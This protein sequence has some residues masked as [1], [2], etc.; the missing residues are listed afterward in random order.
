MNTII[1]G[2]GLAGL[3]LAHSL[4]ENTVILEKEEQLGGLC[5]S[6][7]FKDIM[8]DIG[9]HIIFSKDEETLNFLTS[10]VEC[11]K[12]RRSNKIFFKGRFIKYPFENELSALSKQDRDY[13]LNTFL[14]NPNK[15]MKAK[16]MLDFFTNTFGKGITDLYLKPYNKKI[17]KYDPEHM[18]TQMVERIPI[19]PD[20]D[21][22]KSAEGIATEGYIHQLDF[23]YPKKNGIQD[24]ISS[25]AK[26]IN[27]KAE[28]YNNI[29][30]NRII[31]KDNWIIETNHGNFKSDRIIN[32]MPLHE[33]FKYLERTPNEIKKT[34]SKLEYNSIYIVILNIL[35][36]NLE[37]NFA[38]MV[39]DQ[40]IIFHRVSKLNFLDDSHKTS[41]LMAEVTFREGDHYSKMSKEEIIK[42]VVDDLEKLNFINKKNVISTDLQKIKYAYVIYTLDHK[43]NISKIMNYLNRIG[44]LCCGR[45][46]EFKYLNMD[47]VIK[48]SKDLAEKVNKS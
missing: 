44:I 38:V 5:R 30:I 29:K 7:A 40:N 9:P 33:L 19:P 23:Y 24:L 26:K 14:N 20:E 1:L 43:K 36:D 4:N 22:I 39:P 35:E 41:Y 11:N 18:D 47:G 37:N 27:L 34:L 28:I 17:W 10:S 6:F 45:F 13:C 15:G 16:N 25:L 8:Y 46:A 3:S 48:H 21:I 31:K 2:G 42:N 12:Y 32:C